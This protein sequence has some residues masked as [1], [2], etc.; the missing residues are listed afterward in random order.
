MTQRFVSYMPPDPAMSTLTMLQ[1]VF[2]GVTGSLE[3]FYLNVCPSSQP[4]P[5]VF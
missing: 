5:T 2:E 1:A 4:L 3:F